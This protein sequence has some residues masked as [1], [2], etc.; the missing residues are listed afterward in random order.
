MA[1]TL[2]SLLVLASALALLAGCGNTQ[3]GSS[4]AAQGDKA[5]HKK[6]GNA[7]DDVDSD[8]K[9]G[10]KNG[11]KNKDKDKDKNSSTDS[12]KDEDSGKVS[13][14]EAKVT[15]A[16]KALPKFAM[17]ANQF[18]CGFCHIKIMGDMVSTTAVPP[19]RNDWVGTVNGN[20]LI[21]GALNVGQ[22]GAKID[23]AGDKKEN[24]SGPEVPKGIPQISFNDAK[25]KAT[26]TLKGTSDTGPITISKAITGNTVLIGTDS[27]PLEIKGDVFVDGDLIIKGRFTGIGTIYATGN[28]FV[29]FDLLAKHSP[30]PY[31]DD[32]GSAKTKGEGAAK[33]K[34]LDG[35][36]LATPKSV[37]IGNANSGVIGHPT[38]PIDSRPAVKAMYGWF[39]QAKY[40][41]LYEKAFDCN[42]G[43]AN[44]DRAVNA[45]DAFIYAGRSIEGFASGS[46]FSIRGGMI[47]DYFLVL[48]A[49][50]GCVGSSRISPV[51][52]RAMN[53][54]YVEYDWRLATGKYRVL[55]RLGDAL[56]GP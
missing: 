54:S 52:G 36:A 18:E 53:T 39:T 8:G 30:F 42:S 29:P 23:V 5:G 51:H 33:D 31:P 56:G 46:A 35:L 1:H 14:E 27:L 50:N 32:A 9:D 26:G 21:N 15:K 2:K 25:A 12:T 20:W 45:V 3:F 43:N 6:D 4:G 55:E 16:L 17:L 24:Y 13:A 37:F 28:I 49:A 40:E 47:T 34:S 22:S 44:R 7:K 19:A 38:S 41:A 10:G 11:D 48:N